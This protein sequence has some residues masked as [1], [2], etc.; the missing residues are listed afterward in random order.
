MGVMTG[1]VERFSCDGEIWEVARSIW[2]LLSFDPAI[3][4]AHIPYQ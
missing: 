3:P 1:L 2:L 4:T